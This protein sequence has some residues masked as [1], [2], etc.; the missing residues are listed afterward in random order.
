M[1]GLSERIHLPL[2][3]Y[4]CMLREVEVVDG[5]VEC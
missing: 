1:T 4:W 3:A 2:L 5:L